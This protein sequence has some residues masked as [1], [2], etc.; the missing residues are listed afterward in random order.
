[1]QYKAATPEEYI[2]QLPPERQKVIREL[3]HT[4]LDNIPE[5]FH[6][7]ISYGMLGYVVPHSK[8]P[9]GYHCDPKLPLPFMNL[10]SQKNFVAV[11]HSGI[12]ADPE[13][14][15]WFVAEYPK[16]CKRKLDMGKSCIRFKYMEDIPF[17]LIGELATKMTVE[18]WITLY[19]KNVKR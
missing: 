3:R 4:I 1:M 9:D 11:Y 19:E 14:Y 13:L 12:Y 6:E 5:G 10:A 16:H 15:D 17:E 2:E 7:R 8:Y 18:Q